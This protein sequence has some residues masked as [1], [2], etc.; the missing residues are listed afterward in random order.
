MKVSRLVLTVLALALA[1]SPA[2]AVGTERFTVESAADFNAGRLDGTAVHSTARVTP[3]VGTTRIGL[4]DTELGYALARGRDGALYVGT[5]SGGKIIK[6]TG[7]RATVFAETGQLLV[8]ALAFGAND[9]LYAGTLPEGR[10]YAIDARGA[11]RELVRLPETESVFALAYDARRSRLFAA[12]GPNGK[13]FA[14]DARGNAEVF[15]DSEDPHVLCLALEA[16]GK[17][18]AGSSDRALLVRLSA[19]GQAEVL[20]DFAGS[21]VTAIDVRDGVI[22]AAVNEFSAAPAAA[23]PSP[24]ARPQLAGRARP[25]PGKGR[26]YRLE[27]DGRVERIAADEDAHFTS[28]ELAPEDVVYVGLG[29]DGRVLRVAS[30]RSTSTWIDVDERQVLVVDLDAREPVIVTGDSGALYRIRA[31]AAADPTWTSAV[32]DASQRAEWGRLAVR[33]QGRVV[34]ESRTGNTEL[35][36]A[37]WSTWARVPEDAPVTS[38]SARYVQL[39]ARFG[40]DG[41][42]RGLVL[43]Y[44]PANQRAIVRDVTVTMDAA[45]ATAR[46]RGRASATPT[47]KLTWRVDNPDN[48]ELRYRIRVRREDESQYRDLL[49]SDVV[50]TAT[51]YEWDTT[52][53]P[54][55]YYVIEIEANDD[56]SNPAERALTSQSTSDPILVDNHAPRITDLAARGGVVSGRVVDDVGPITRLELAVDGGPFR[57]I[58]PTDRLLDAAEERFEVRPTLAEGAHT[59]AVRATDVGGHQVV[60]ETRIAPSRR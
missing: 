4:A 26:L 27:R 21:E 48:D 3:S 10:I 5:G 51:T 14:I 25:R 37:G 59:V 31:G 41:V 18:L 60:A 7:D 43:S 22:V 49:R 23:P 57:D 55:G 1:S 54:D 8:A 2:H 38:P 34:I 58:L 52:G 11:A 9:V 29:K 6:V 53:V 35:P 45:Q 44:L 15:Y 39:R 36:D 12:T 56:V 50:H 19:P 40:Q 13:V 46:R 32:L 20:Q 33:A 30:D 47:I 16:D 42:L 17:L 24:V 28:V